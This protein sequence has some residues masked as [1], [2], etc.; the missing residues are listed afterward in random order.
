MGNRIK[1]GLLKETKNPPDRRVGITPLQGIELL[2]RFANVSLLVQPSNLRG[3]KD[4]E[5][6][7]HGH[8]LTEDISA[9]EIL[10]GIKEVDI[11][12]LQPN[13]TYIFFS[14]TAKKQPHN[15]KLLQEII[16]KK[17]TLIDYEYL[18]D[19]NNNRLVAFGHWAG[20]VGAYNALVGWGLKYKTYTLERAYLC[21]DMIEMVDEL[22][23][24]KLPSIKILITG[25]GRVANGAQETLS[26]LNLKKVSPQD[27]LA[28]TFNEPVICQIEPEHYVKHKDGK[29]FDLP[30]F[31]CQPSEYV[32]TFLP[33]TKVTDIF[34]PCHFWDP[35]SPVF[36]TKEGMRA[37]DFKM[38][39]IADVSCDL[40]Y[41]VPSTLR[42]SSIAS[43]FYG[44]NPVTE[45]EDDA[46]KPGMITVMA[47]DNLPGE[48]PRD[49]SQFFGEKL[50]NNI[51]PSLFGNDEDGIIERATIV[52]NGTL[53]DRFSYLADYASGKE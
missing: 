31:F 24:V 28:K 47:I 7:L 44:Y 10:I 8:I 39:V 12:K 3:Y 33:F 20:V 52:K 34:I 13:K 9:C 22:K 14:H 49:A 25:G 1:I 37:K 29:T 36:M 51:F 40:I 18:T 15:R 45:S 19:K 4:E 32:S 16:S 38:S 46:W 27:F 48:L 17:I 35:R 11:A 26:H 50:L 42:A 5:Y 30:N 23:K 53:T 21:H 6:D 2:K 43:P 41:P